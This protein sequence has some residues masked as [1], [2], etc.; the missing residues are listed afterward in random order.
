MKFSECIRRRRNPG[1]SQTPPSPPF[2]FFLTNSHLET[3]LTPRRARNHQPRGTDA[4]HVPP[5]PPPRTDVRPVTK[6]WTSP[7]PLQRPRRDSQRD[8]AASVNVA[9]QC[10]R[11]CLP[12]C[13]T[14]RAPPVGRPPPLKAASKAFIKMLVTIFA[15]AQ[16]RRSSVPVPPENLPTT[17]HRPQTDSV[18]CVT[19]C[20]CLL[21]VYRCVRAFQL[22]VVGGGWVGG[23][24]GCDGS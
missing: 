19:T 18:L 8:A 23:W 10:L 20:M 21:E 6:G 5:E 22:G 13:C 2:F 3:D 7:Q 12:S 9:P 11:Q 4:S 24:G 17:L 14:A 15:A 1:G 16:R